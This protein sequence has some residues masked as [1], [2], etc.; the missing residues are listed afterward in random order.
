MAKSHRSSLVVASNSVPQQPD[1][2]RGMLLAGTRED[3]PVDPQVPGARVRP[4]VEDDVRHVRGVDEL[5]ARLERSGVPDAAGTGGRH[6]AVELQPP[7]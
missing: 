3:L 2:E 7:T 6:Q 1:P 4:E 5:P